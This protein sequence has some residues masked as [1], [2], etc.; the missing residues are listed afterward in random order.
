MS[1]DL[2]DKT[3]RING[4]VRDSRVPKLAF[5]DICKVLSEL[6]SSNVYV[7]SSSGKVLGVSFRD[8]DN[9]ISEIPVVKSKRIDSKIASRMKNVLST[10]ENVN[11]QLLGL[12]RDEVRG[13]Q[14][15][16]TPV[17][18]A[19]NHLGALFLYRK[20]EEYDIEDIILCEYTTT[21]I[22]LEMQRSVM[23][24]KSSE[25]RMKQ[26]VDSAVSILSPL[27]KKAIM[28]VLG[29]VDSGEST[30]VVSQVAKES[31]ITRTVII[32]ALKKMES[33]G[34]L[35]TKSMGVKGTNIKVLNSIIYE[36]FDIM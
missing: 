19:G 3:R 2:L 30:I 36:E 24:E 5:N 16:I 31:G 14:A 4:L 17:Y 28:N 25:S 15:M 11:L 18:V 35:E 22:G 33:A 8:L 9:V 23:E 13:L 10:K 21:V 29:E 1:V 7:I 20:E 26:D 6:L 34:L 32:N 27:E 12:S